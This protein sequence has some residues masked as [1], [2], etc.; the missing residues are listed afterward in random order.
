MLQALNNKINAKKAFVQLEASN[1]IDKTF[2]F[3]SSK[4][5]QKTSKISSKKASLNVDFTLHN[6]QNSYERQTFFYC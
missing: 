2:K 5:I 1:L 6:L 4:T 3:A